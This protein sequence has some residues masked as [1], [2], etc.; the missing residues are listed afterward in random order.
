MNTS[1]LGGK[2]CVCLIFLFFVCSVVYATDLHAQDANDAQAK[3]TQSA[4][5]QPIK[6]NSDS[7]QSNEQAKKLPESGQETSSQSL[8][9]KAKPRSKK[10]Q[11]IFRPSEEISED[12]AVPFPV[13]I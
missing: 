8:P 9:T 2:F 7:E 1:A 10:D 12:F 11:E 6:G 5:T 4:G 3:E 13:D